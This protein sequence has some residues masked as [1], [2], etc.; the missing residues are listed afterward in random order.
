MSGL[1]MFLDQMDIACIGSEGSHQ[2]VTHKRDHS[3]PCTN[4]QIE[5][6]SALDSL[7]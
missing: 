6:H 1:E 5:L 2:D 7:W 3:H 4:G